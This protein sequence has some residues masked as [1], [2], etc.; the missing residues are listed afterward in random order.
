VGEY[1]EQMRELLLHFYQHSVNNRGVGPQMAMKS[2]IRGDRGNMVFCSNNASYIV[3]FVTLLIQW[4]QFMFR[5]RELHFTD[6]CK[7]R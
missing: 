4:K 3:Y 2:N 1:F 7:N 6:F 5:G